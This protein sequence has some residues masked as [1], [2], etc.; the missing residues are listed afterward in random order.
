MSA[1]AKY[2]K[3]YFLMMAYAVISAVDLFAGQPWFKLI[4]LPQSLSAC[5]INHVVQASDGLVWLGTSCGLVYYDG[6]EFV[7]TGFFDEP[8]KYIAEGSNQQLIITC[9]SGK[10]ALLKSSTGYFELPGLYQ[11]NGQITAALQTK[12]EAL[13]LAIYG[14]GIYRIAGDN[15][16][17]INSSNSALTD[18]Y[19]Y[20]LLP[21]T[22]GRIWAATD[23]GI[24]IIDYQNDAFSVSHLT[25]TDGLPDIMVVSLSAAD[26]NHLFA[27]GYEGGFSLIHQPTAKIHYTTKGRQW[28]HGA[29]NGVVQSGSRFWVATQTNGLVRLDGRGKGHRQFTQFEDREITRFQQIFQDHEG[30]IWAVAANAIVMIQATGFE[31]FR[32]DSANVMRNIHALMFDTKDDLW[33]ATESGLFRQDVAMDE[34]NPA[35]T[36]HLPEHIQP[37]NITCLHRDEAGRIWIGTFGNGLLVIDEEDKPPAVYT[38]ENGFVNDNILSIASDENFVWFATLG[39]AARTPVTKAHQKP[40][41]E[42]FS[43]REGPGNKFIYSVITDSRGRVWFATDGTGIILLQD[44]LF[45]RY[46]VESGLSSEKIYTMAEDENG[47]IWCATHDNKVFSYSGNKFHEATTG[48][49]GQYSIFALHPDAAGNLLIVHENGVAVYNTAD[50]SALHYG[51]NYGIQPIRPEF[52]ST[53]TGR[54]GTLWIG[55]NDHLMAYS[56]PANTFFKTPQPLITGVQV[57]SRKVYPEGNS[58]FAY[59]ENYL[60]L[61]FAGLWYQNPEAV[62]YR[63]KLVGNDLDWNYTNDRRVAYSRLTPGDYTFL[64]EASLNDDFRRAESTQYTFTIG[65]PLW[66]KWWFIATA[67]AAL[68]LTVY[69]FFRL[70]MERLRRIEALEKEKLL[71]QFETLRSQVNPHFLFNSFSTLMSLIDDDKK[72]AQDYVEKLSAFFRNILEYRDQN[73]ITL[74]EELQIA[75]NYLHLQQQRY[76]KNLIVDVQ[77]EA[78]YLKALTPPLTLQLLLENAIKH[79]VI[80]NAKPLTIKIFVKNNRLIVENNLQPKNFAGESTGFGLKTIKQRYS[81]ISEEQVEIRQRDGIFRVMLPLII[82]T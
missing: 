1:H 19:F 24:Q 78:L 41:F 75:R 18:T 7:L 65:R 31:F 15:Y 6:Y 40:D 16:Q 30:N 10:T 26:D 13:W 66:Q 12:D 46:G 9:E 29:V 54:D 58:H 51:S 22:L 48:L 69:F 11:G 64:V 20:R 67:V 3:V 72:M 44:G 43:G 25:Y 76:G 5:R 34:N 21:D 17:F 62:L 33:Y 77:V 70:R 50:S 32:H 38:Q 4:T 27:G 71:F 2:I 56:P 59:N 35:T 36:I 68:G 61:Q 60:T 37:K 63:V 49:D 42:I 53:A 57:L 23:G 52:N 45:K 79:N 80:S 47:T 73:L 8:V 28:I 82:E 74:G 55:A 39:G 81:Y 14:E